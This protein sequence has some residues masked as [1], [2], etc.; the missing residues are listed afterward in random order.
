MGHRV[1]RRDYSRTCESCNWLRLMDVIDPPCSSNT[2]LGTRQVWLMRSGAHTV[3]EMACLGCGQYVGFQIVNAHEPSERWKN[4]A[5]ILERKF[6]YI[7]S[8]YECTPEDPDSD[9]NSYK[10]PGTPLRLKV[11]EDLRM[12]HKAKRMTVLPSIQARRPSAP[13]KPLPAIPL[14]VEAC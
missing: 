2:S 9:A 1:R 12:E 8:V 3:R 5:Y 6:L 13:I 10:W 7:H 14:P 4:G 11:V